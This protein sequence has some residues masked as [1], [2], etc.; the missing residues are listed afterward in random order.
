M[1]ARRLALVLRT[2]AAVGAGAA[3]GYAASASG[4]AIATSND[5]GTVTFVVRH[6]ESPTDRR[7]RKRISIQCRSGEIAV[8]GSARLRYPQATPTAARPVPLFVTESRPLPPDA[9]SPT[10]WLVVADAIARYSRPWSVQINV[11]CAGPGPPQ[12]GTATT[13]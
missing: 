13:P 1:A 7:K 9:A 11:T 8:A 3:I 5:P 6:D 12:G 2:A 4:P 10:G